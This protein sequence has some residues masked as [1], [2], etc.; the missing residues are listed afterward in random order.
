MRASR[1]GTGPRWRRY[2]PTTWST[3]DRRRVVN[4]GIRRGRD[5]VI[6]DMQAAVEVGCRDHTP[7]PSL[8]PAGSASP[9]LVPVLQQ[10]ARGPESSTSSCCSIAEIDADERIVGAGRVRPRRHR[11]RLRRTRRPIP[12]RR[13]GRPRAH[14]VGHLSGLRRTQPARTPSV[15]TGLGDI[16]HRPRRF[17]SRRLI[18]PHP[19]VPHGT[20]RRTSTFTSRRC[21]G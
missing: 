21:I 15:D 11:C 17:R 1:P 3:D 2:W 13:S 7:E 6:A 19:S 16:D 20:S 9:S 12:R 4:A 5:V 10:R 14:V 18:W 8:R